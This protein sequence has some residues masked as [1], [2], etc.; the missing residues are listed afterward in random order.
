[1]QNRNDPDLFP[2]IRFATLQKYA[3][4]WAGFMRGIG[5]SLKSIALYKPPVQ[6]WPT[7]DYLVLFRVHHIGN[8]SLMPEDIRVCLESLPIPHGENSYETAQAFSIN[9][10]DLPNSK[11]S[12][13]QQIMA[14]GKIYLNVPLFFLGLFYGF[15]EVYR[16]PPID[17]KGCLQT[18]WV[19]MF[20]TAPDHKEYYWIT[21]LPS[22]LC[23]IIYEGEQTVSIR[24]RQDQKDREAVEAWAREYF[25]QFQ[26]TQE[27]IPKLARIV[28][29]AQERA[30]AA[31]S[32]SP[33]CIQDW[34]RPLHP[35]YTP[36]KPGHKKTKK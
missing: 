18:E 2:K 7:F 19:F 4:S 20:S 33:R 9:K 10:A 6:Y 23:W 3:D 24:K 27:A 31:K 21:D 36:G 13:Q 17:L 34:I 35:R 11:W 1:M 22:H 28:E 8:R 30:D 26:K 29:L 14:E 32:Y 16:D 25:L 12:L 15:S 5:I